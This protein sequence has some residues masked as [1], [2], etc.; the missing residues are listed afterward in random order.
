MRIILI[1]S[2]LITQIAFGQKYADK[3]YYLIEGLDLT[4]VT[5][6]D[7]LFIENALKAYHAESKKELKLKYIDEIIENVWNEDV[8]PKYNIWLLKTVKEVLN[9]KQSLSDSEIRTYLSLF[10]GTH[11]NIGYLADTRGNSDKAIKYYQLSLQIDQ[12]LGDQVGVAQILNNIAGVYTQ[13][14]RVEESLKYNLEAL[15]VREAIQDSAGMAQSYNNIGAVYSGAAGNDSLAI[16]YTQKSLDIRRAIGD[17][18]GTAICLMNIVKYN[19]VLGEKKDEKRQLLEAQSIFESIGNRYGLGFVL[20]N[21]GN[22]YERIDN[23]D[24]ASYFYDEAIKVSQE[25]GNKN[26]LGQALSSKSTLNL[27]IFNEQKNKDPQLLK[28]IQADAETGLRLGKEIGYPE[29]VMISTKALTQI[30]AE[31]NKAKSAVDMFDLYIE[32]RDSLNNI[33][34]R[35]AVIEAQTKYV[36]E[37]QKAVDDITRD[38]E[39]ALQKQQSEKQRIITIIIA[40]SAVILASLL[41]I[42]FRRLKLSRLQTKKIEEQNKKID[43]Q[44]QKL[45]NTHQEITDSINYAKR[46]QTALLPTKKAITEA[47]SNSFVLY[48]PKDVVAGDFYWSETV[49]DLNFI[50]AADCTGHGVPGAMVSVVC[51][52]C[53]NRAVREFKLKTPAEILDKTRDLVIAEFE[54]SDEEVKDGMDIS[55]ISISGMTLQFSGAN[56]P[57]WIVRNQ[58]LIEIKGDKQPIGKHVNHTPFTN[59]TVELKAG[60]LI[61]LF[62]DG[63]AD[64]FG[65]KAG[66]KMKTAHLR[67]TILAS[68]E[69]DFENQET[70]LENVFNDW[71]GELDQLDDVCLIGIKV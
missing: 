3:N 29:L 55:M 42:I 39:V 33:E 8:W 56:N 5:Q 23:F 63:Y 40:I 53:L 28:T 7:S 57:L 61:Y 4:K 15:K 24:S 46:I 66:K 43:L 52:G 38:K 12:I 14:G 31:Q 48:L 21:L 54:K 26:G 45:E 18:N 67:K 10:S 44:H 71:K 50:A 37:K 19:G 34:S 6:S 35:T 51:N 2:F 62:T 60:D 11:N 36:Y 68:F 49:G 17:L 25:I 9:N 69:L 47:F 58:E 59:H 1:I 22:Y 27:N 20:N 13:Q 32:M 64:Q 70:V 41:F 16:V 30:Y 65:G